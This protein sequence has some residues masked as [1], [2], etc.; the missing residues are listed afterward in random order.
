MINYRERYSKFLNDKLKGRTKL[1]VLE[2]GCGSLK[3]I[4]FNQ[5]VTLTGIDI[6]AKQLE[7]NIYLD[8]KIQGDLHTYKFQPSSF[9]V[10]V[11]W[12]V[13][14]HLEKPNLA[15]DN[16][17]NSLKPEGLLVIKLP[18][19]LSL[20]GLITKYSPYSIHVLYYKLVYKK[21][22]AGKN[23]SG[24]FK[25]FLKPEVSPPSLKKYAV[26]RGMSVVYFDLFDIM[27][28]SYTFKRT[29]FPKMWRG[30]Y[31][32]F[33]SLSTFLSFGIL[34]GSECLIIME[35]A[36]ERSPKVNLT[37]NREAVPAA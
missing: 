14:E 33:K 5:S 28:E 23:D 11:C 32:F 10:I 19:L 9:D 26:S 1:D 6:S 31:R 3:K 15:M 12:D 34:N 22:D 21:A 8:K 37:I 4:S 35:K 16:M 20:K 25:T 18:N 30:V 27:D 29:R 7:R 2:A 24:P 17:V 36:K 13:L